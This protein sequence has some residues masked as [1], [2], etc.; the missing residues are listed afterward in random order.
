MATVAMPPPAVDAYETFQ[1]NQSLTT[2]YSQQRCVT[3]GETTLR[4]SDLY[5]IAAP[6]FNYRALNLSDDERKARVCHAQLAMNLG[7]FD[8]GPIDG[9]PDERTNRGLGALSQA[10]NL[11]TADVRDVSVQIALT[12]AMQRGLGL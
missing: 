9:I 4:A 10:Y 6:Q 1:L 2:T 12:K 3:E 8:A 7:D 11:Q 5:A